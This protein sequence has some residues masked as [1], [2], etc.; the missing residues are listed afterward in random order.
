MKTADRLR[1]DA[2]P[3]WK[4]IMEHPF[5]T[6]LYRGELSP[7]KFRFYILQDYHYLITAMKN[8]GVIA[9]RADSVEELREVA[10]ILHLEA[11]SEFE[12][13]SSFLGRLG[14]TVKEAAETEPIPASV[15]YGSFLIST[16]STRPFAESIT[17]V[18]PCF[19]SYAEIAAHHRT[20]L[21]SNQNDLYRGWAQ[22][23]STGDY[24]SLV[25]KIK[26]LVN[27]AGEEYPYQKLKRVFSTASKY[28]YMF[29]EAV[30]RIEE[31]PL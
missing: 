4:Q 18:L 16:S 3:L 20:A 14:H 28:E 1:I 12:G 13:Y 8:F 23:Y 22:V 25:E 9:S 24:L 17:S 2:D 29:W 15:S 21:E 5:V 11:T 31:W 26:S 7:D 10:E 30:Y 19:W 6:E 27:K